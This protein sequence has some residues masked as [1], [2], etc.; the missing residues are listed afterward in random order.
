MSS[1][2]RSRRALIA[3]RLAIIVMLAVGA[4]VGL[5]FWGLEPERAGANNSDSTSRELF[6]AEFHRV[7]M[8][9]TS[10]P[11]VLLISVDTLRADHMG[12]YGYRR[13]TTPR[14]DQFAK[15]S[16]VFDR[17]YATAPFTPPSVVSMLTGR[18]PYN[19]RVRMFWQRVTAENITIAD[20]LRRIGY[21][22]AAVVSNVV[23]SD[24]ACGLGVRFEH[25]DDR[26][27]EPEPRR[28]HMRERRAAGTTDAAITWLT[29]ARDANKPSFLWVHYNDPHGPYTPPDDAPVDFTHDEPKFIAEDQLLDYVKEP[30]LLD[31]FEYVDRYDEEIA[32]VDR[33]IGR[34]LDAYTSIGLADDAL[35][36]LTADH[37]EQMM[38][39]ERFFFCH[40]YNVYE[41]V[42]HI[43]LLVRFKSIPVRRVAQPVSIV[44][45]MPTILDVVGLPIPGGLDG[46][47]LARGIR[48]RPPYAE[49]PDAEVKGRLI[50]TF[51]YAE[52]KIVLQ[53]GRSNI[54]RRSWAYDLRSD[55]HESNPLPVDPAESAYVAM[56]RIIRGDPDPAG[57]P[58]SYAKGIRPTGA[59]VADHADHDALKTLRSLGYVE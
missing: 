7:E 23:L 6:P 56:D 25:Y 18:Y 8:P 36:I 21:Q 24:D 52:R 26:V 33:E 40:G 5:C 41:S 55:P 28:P 47:S 51:V 12:L 9:P 54:P 2:S 31:G 49:G 3:T 10:G 46:Y 59:A 37:G 58:T 50:R 22:T 19:H 35:I 53:H 48:Q 13:P 44:D 29:G 4:L 45:V 16:R 43:P 15:T 17:A 30:D 42:I 39:G 38:D 34:L 11:H 27:S 20:H 57:Q 1:Q 14:I 32:Y